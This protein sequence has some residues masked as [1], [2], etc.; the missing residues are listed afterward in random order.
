M[1]QGLG[2]ESLYTPEV[3]SAFPPLALCPPRPEYDCFWDVWCALHVRSHLC[4][5]PNSSLRQR[6][7]G[8]FYSQGNRLKGGVLKY[9][10]GRQL[11]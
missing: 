4:S 9:T 10:E 6:K 11:G 8:Q 2:K 7:R 3:H 1:G 5:D